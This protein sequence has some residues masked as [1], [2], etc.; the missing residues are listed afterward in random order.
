MSATLAS[1]AAWPPPLD[2]S[3]FDVRPILGVCDGRFVGCLN[4]PAPIV[5]LAPDAGRR[6]RYGV[7]LARGPWLARLCPNCLSALGALGLLGP[8]AV[9]VATRIRPRRTR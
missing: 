2:D 5:L 6:T 9:P 4:R 3:D 7:P 8:P 1:E